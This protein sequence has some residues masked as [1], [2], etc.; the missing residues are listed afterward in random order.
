MKNQICEIEGSWLRKLVIDDKTYWNI[1]EDVPTRQLP[2]MDNIA[3]SDWRYRED[4]IWLKYSYMKIA[5][6]W[7]IRMEE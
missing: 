3:P 7:K 6:Q 4:L 2:K 5:Q 1:D